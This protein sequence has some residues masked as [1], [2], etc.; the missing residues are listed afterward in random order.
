MLGKRKPAETWKVCKTFL[1]FQVFMCELMC[2]KYAIFLGWYSLSL[3]IFIVKIDFCRGNSVGSCK[4]LCQMF[5]FDCANDILI[6]SMS[7]YLNLS[8]VYWIVWMIYNRTF[9]LEWRSCAR[10]ETAAINIVKDILD[11]DIFVLGFWEWFWQI[12][13][14][15]CWYEIFCSNCKAPHILQEILWTPILK[16]IKWTSFIIAR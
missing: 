8:C 13:F 5:I 14:A 3:R 15:S 1:I 11:S 10:A 9:A 12:V 6:F 7:Y 2:N 16:L 4:I